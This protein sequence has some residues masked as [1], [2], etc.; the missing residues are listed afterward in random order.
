VSRSPDVDAGDE[1]PGPPPAGALGIEV[2]RGGPLD[3]RE[4][5]ALGVAITATATG[6]P[7]ST[8]HEHAWARAARIEGVGRPRIDRPSDLPRVS[9]PR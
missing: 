6:G 4:T 3:A 7:E 5:A 8:R 2:V 1:A 9:R